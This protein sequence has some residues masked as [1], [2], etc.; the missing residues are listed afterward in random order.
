MWKKAN[1]FGIYVAL[2]DASVEQLWQQRLW[3]RKLPPSPSPCHDPLHH[4][5]LWPNIRAG[6]A[7]LAML[8]RGGAFSDTSSLLCVVR[9]YHLSDHRQPCEALDSMTSGVRQR[10]NSSELFRR[11]YIALRH[12]VSALSHTPGRA[13]RISDGCVPSSRVDSVA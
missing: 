12:E 1:S 9:P 10:R 13:T 11:L 5:G 8:T 2:D 6:L 4:Y 7:F 3:N